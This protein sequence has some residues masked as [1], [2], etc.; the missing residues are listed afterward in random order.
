[1]TEL[2]SFR[3]NER[4]GTVTDENKKL[5]EI[6]AKLAESLAPRLKVVGLTM[7]GDKALDQ[8]QQDAA[9]IGRRIRQVLQA[10]SD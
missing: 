9:K 1:M 4:M 5:L 10:E 3:G 6:A 8:E 7:A 2:L